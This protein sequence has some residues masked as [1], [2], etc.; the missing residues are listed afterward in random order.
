MQ[1]SA[2]LLAAPRSSLLLADGELEERVDITLDGELEGL[3]DITLG[4]ERECGT[5]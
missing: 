1:L 5:Y 2:V 3:V 4:G